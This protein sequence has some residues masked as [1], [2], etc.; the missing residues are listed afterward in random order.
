MNTG[1]IIGGTITAIIFGYTVRFIAISI[2]NNEADPISN[3]GVDKLIQVN[4]K[5]LERVW[6]L[7][8]LRYNLYNPVEFLTGC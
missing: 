6:N 2:N 8:Y 7:I 1:L 4:D 3:F 5:E